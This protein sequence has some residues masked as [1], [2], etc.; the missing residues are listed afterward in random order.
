MQRFIAAMTVPVL[1][2]PG[3]Y[4]QAADTAK[5]LR[6]RYF[7]AAALV[8]EQPVAAFKR[9]RCSEVILAAGGVAIAGET[10]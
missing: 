8:V 6:K 3:G 1:L 10:E 5:G 4:R 7:F 9:F 2:R